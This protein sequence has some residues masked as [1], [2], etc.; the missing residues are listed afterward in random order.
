MRGGAVR[1]AERWSSARRWLAVRLD[2]IGD[3][4]M[5]TPALR[6]LRASGPGRHL[7][8][9]TSSAGGAVAALIPEVDAVIA[10]DPPWMKA[11]PERASAALEYAMAER[12]A[13]GRFEAAVIFTVY[14]QSPL[15]AAL[16]LWLAGIP[17]RLAHCRENPYQLL[18]DWIPDPEPTRLVRHEVRRQLD[19]VGAVG[20][21]TGDER[22]SLR[23]PAPARRR[24]RD[25]LD[26]LGLAGRP[27]VLVHPGATAPSRRYPPESFAEV[28][29]GLAAAGLPVLLA[30]GP[31]TVRWSPR[32]SAPRPPARWPVAWTSRN[33]RP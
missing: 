31:G 4:L 33:W 25:R 32:S 7:T 22:L 15:P 1:Q 16:L 12:L 10:Y 24:V 3:V 13:A 28:V 14:S 27:W 26:K 2:A 30:G 19:L 8:L 21:A 6:A 17:L 29:R 23:V 9:L 5:T 20:A 18:T 11:T